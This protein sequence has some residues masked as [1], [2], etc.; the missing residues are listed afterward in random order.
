MIRRAVLS[1]LCAAALA[2]PAAAQAKKELVFSILSAES[3]SSAEKDWTPFLADMSKAL[4]MPV[5]AYYGS[6]YTVLVEA[7]RFR[8]TDLGW[9]TNLSGLETVRRANAEVF[10]RSVNPSG[11]D[12][13]Q[14]VIVVK[15]GSGITLARF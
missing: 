8:Q 10:A 12:G 3:Q 13:Y 5:K 11:V 9:F 15:K 6:N 1:L 14:A 4:G 2:G 7:M